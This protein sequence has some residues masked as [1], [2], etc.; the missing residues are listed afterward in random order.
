MPESRA[1]GR[2]WSLESRARG[3]AWP[4]LACLLVALTLSACVT[5]TTEPR[6]VLLEEHQQVRVEHLNCTEAIT[7]ARHVAPTAQGLDP[8]GFRLLT[9]NIHKQGDKGWQRDLAAFAHDAD[10]VLLQELVLEPE[11]RHVI[12]GA[13][14][15]WAMASSFLNGN[16]DIG[17]LTAARV[18]PVATCTQRVVEPLLRI[19]KSSVITWYALKGTPT[20]VA[21]VNMHAINFSLSLG[22]YREQLFAMRDALAQHQGPIVFAGDL[23]TWTQGRYDAVNAVA[24][25]LGLTEISYAPDKRRLFFGKQ[26]DHIFVRGLS[27][28]ES[29]AY[30]VTSSDHNPVMATLRLH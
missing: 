7:K 22:A 2:A 1:R 28:V 23:N 18:S 9:W 14:L 6:A 5:V 24:H 29:A 15:R 3:S 30:E 11:I 25:S 21:I 19:P 10:V 27:M 20:T 12:E 17:V 26:L 13:S 16:I 4:R 8:G